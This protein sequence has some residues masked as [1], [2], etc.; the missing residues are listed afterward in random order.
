MLDPKSIPVALLRQPNAKPVALTEANVSSAPTRVRRYWISDAKIPGLA[1]RVS[2][3]GGRAYYVRGRIGGGRGA[4]QLDY[5]L[6]DPAR[7]PLA[8]ARKQARAVLARMQQGVDPRVPKPGDGRISALLDEYGAHLRRR[9]IVKVADVMSSLRR[10]LHRHRHSTI[11]TL[12]RLALLAHVDEIEASGKPGAAQ[13]FRKHAGAFLNWAVSQ[14]HLTASPLAGYRRPRQTRAERL[15]RPKLTFTGT[16]ALRRLWRALGAA[17][18]PFEAMLRLGLLTGLR[19]GE[20]AN[21]QWAHVELDGSEPR[22]TLPAEVTKTGEARA[23]PLGPLSAAL[24]S[25]QSRPAG[26]DLVFPGRGQ[27]RI[28][29]WTQ[30][31]APVKAEVP[32][33]GLHALRRSFRSGLSDLGVSEGIAEVMVGHKRKG[34]VGIYDRSEVWPARVAAQARWEAHI[35]GL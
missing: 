34:L 3:S 18:Q 5:R 23:L 25:S 17:G 21:L 13:D 6:G 22:I 4:Q 24:L 26:T 10:N 19:R 20:L 1:L 27:K 28:S 15:A 7:M 31:L 2:P 12:D 14:G 30:R 29:G 11:A 9:R 8:E 35:A 33:F 32:G 16:D